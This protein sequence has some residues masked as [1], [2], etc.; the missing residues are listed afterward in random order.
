MRHASGHGDTSGPLMRLKRGLGTAPEGA[1]AGAAGKRALLT[2]T[3]QAFSSA[4]NFVVGVAVARIAGP[5]GLGGFALAYG[6]WLVLAALHRSLV[7]D[8][9]AIEN[10]AVQPDA[11][12]RLSRGF[13]SEVSLALAA[14]ACLAVVGVPL[15]E[16]GQRTF[17]LAMLAVIPWLPFLLVQDYWR[18]TGFMRR[19]PGKALANDTVFNVVQGICFALV[20]IGRVHSVVAVIASWG[21]GAAAGALYGLWQF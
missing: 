18:W 7:T 11:P 15:F 19:E 12:A 4:S 10:D 8:P 17:G 16:E 9:M 21:A 6:C 2:T 20:A 13:A 3:D 14:A 1:T 5:Q